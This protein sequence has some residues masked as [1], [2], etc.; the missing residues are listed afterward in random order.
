M[1]KKI[2]FLSIAFIALPFLSHAAT[3]NPNNVLSDGEYLDSSSMSS[4]YIQEFLNSKGSGLTNVSVNVEGT[5]KS[6]STIFYEAAKTYGVSQKLLVAT[7]QKEQSAVTDG[8]LSQNQLDKLMG[9]GIYSGSDYD[10]YLGVYNQINYSAKQFRRYY[11]YHGN[12]NW[13]KGK[14]GMTGDDVEVTPDN[15]ATAGLYNY[16]PHAGADAGATSDDT[17]HGGNFLFWKTWN[18]WFVTNHPSGTLVREEGQVGI[19]Y[20]QN[21]KKKPFWSGKVFEEY[22]FQEKL[23]VEVSKNELDAYSTVSP[24]KYID[25]T[26][27]QGPDGGVYVIEG[28]LKRAITS[29]EAFDNLGYKTENIVQSTE[30]EL[31]LYGRGEDIT[32]KVSYPNGTLVES[33]IN[34]GV[35]LLEG[36][37]RR[38]VQDRQIFENRFKWE[39]IVSISNTRFNQYS[40]GSPVLFKDGTLVRD[41]AGSIFVIENGLRRHV[42]RPSVFTGLG[43]NIENVINVP[44]WIIL[45]HPGGEAIESY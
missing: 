42:A 13:Q 2:L 44:D 7:A 19:Y 26:V 34:G 31:N 30:E 38:P 20:I 22:G 11:D 24:M 39:R 14:T 40:E 9:Y 3:Y 17:G 12:Y 45:M 8:D 10:E 37:H 15:K 23:V 1:Y 18:G 21:G 35:Y 32:S 41:E 4:N 25:G 33:P 29:R 28:G 43:Y 6:V 36:N 16:T 5:V 27:V